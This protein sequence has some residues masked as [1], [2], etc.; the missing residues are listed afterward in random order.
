MKDHNWAFAGSYV[1]STLYP[2]YTNLW[3]ACRDCGRGRDFYIE[4]N[5]RLQ[6]PQRGADACRLFNDLER[7]RDEGYMIL[8]VEGFFY[9]YDYFRHKKN[10]YGPKESG[11]KSESVYKRLL[12]GAF[13]EESCPAKTFVGKIR[14]WWRSHENR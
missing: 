10:P 9:A 13:R 7:L 2:R 8:W 12:S 14:A 5:A 11:W 6:L 1:S 3:C 4:P